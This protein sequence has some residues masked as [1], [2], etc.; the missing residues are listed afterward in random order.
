MC[1]FSDCE[2]T[3]SRTWRA[4][5]VDERVT[6]NRPDERRFFPEPETFAKRGDRFFAASGFV[7]RISQMQIALRKILLHLDGALGFGGRAAEMPRLV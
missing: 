1:C 5:G 7:E 6:E 3:S 2:R 4:S